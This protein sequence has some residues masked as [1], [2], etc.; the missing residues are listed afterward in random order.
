VNARDPD[1]GGTP[2]LKAARWGHADVAAYLINHGA[3]VNQTDTYG[4]PE[5]NSFSPVFDC[6]TRHWSAF[7]PLPSPNNHIAISQVAWAVSDGALAVSARV[8]GFTLRGIL[9]EHRCDASSPSARP[10]CPSR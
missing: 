6:H 9:G 2:L 4:E 3:D 1:Y 5:I 8:F 10:T 7:V